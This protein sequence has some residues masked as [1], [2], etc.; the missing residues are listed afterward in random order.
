MKRTFENSGN[1]IFSRIIHFV[2]CLC[3]TI[4]LQKLVVS[5]MNLSSDFET[6][7]KALLIMQTKI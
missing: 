1:R 7:I 2:V 5:L 4:S 3:L 6:L